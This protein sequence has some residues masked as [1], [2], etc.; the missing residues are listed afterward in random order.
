MNDLPK[1]VGKFSDHFYSHVELI[2]S[3]P[4]SQEWELLQKSLYVSVIDTK[5]AI[6]FHED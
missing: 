6:L 4:H 3:L 5:G 2:H 1:D